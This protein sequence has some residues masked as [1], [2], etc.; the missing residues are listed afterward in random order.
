MMN[1]HDL[2][3]NEIEIVWDSLDVDKSGTID[4]K[5]FSR[6]LE[7]YGVRNVSKEETII[8]QMI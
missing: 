8:I 2:K 4:L 3:K 7:R 6:K 5:E 1:V